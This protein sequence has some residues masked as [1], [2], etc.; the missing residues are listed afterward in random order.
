[1]P[2]PPQIKLI[3]LAPTVSRR[4]RSATPISWHITYLVVEMRP[5]VIKQC[6]A[7]YPLTVSYPDLQ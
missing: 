7:T 4:Q 5:S 6:S 1:M 3:C 2:E